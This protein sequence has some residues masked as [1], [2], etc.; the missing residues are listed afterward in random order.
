MQELKTSVIVDEKMKDNDRREVPAAA[1][2]ETVDVLNREMKTKIMAKKTI[3]SLAIMK[4]LGVVGQH[5][6]YQQQAIKDRDAR[7]D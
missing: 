1:R 6:N 7:V 2:R 3:K 4:S 5:T